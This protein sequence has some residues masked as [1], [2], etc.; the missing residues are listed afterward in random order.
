MSTATMRAPSR[1]N[2][3]AVAL[4]LPHPLSTPPAPTTRA[5]L[6]FS[7]PTLASPSMSWFRCFRDPHRGAE[8]LG[9]SHEAFGHFDESAARQALVDGRYAQRGHGFAVGVEDRGTDR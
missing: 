9:L 3:V 2:R 7:R 5:T 6:P 8:R 1:A 4:P